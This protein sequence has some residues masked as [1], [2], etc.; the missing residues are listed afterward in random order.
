MSFKAPGDYPS[1]AGDVSQRQPQDEDEDGDDLSITSTNAGDNDSEK[2]WDVDDVLAERPDPN[3]PGTRQYLIMWEGFKLE[4]CTW[5]PIENLGDGLFAKW[6]ENKSE[7]DAGVRETFDLATYDAACAER[8]ERHMR[9]NAKRQRLGLPLTIPFPPE[10]ADDASMASPADRSLFY[11][12]D[13]AQEVDEV[14]DASTPSSKSRAAASTPTSPLETATAM[15]KP[16]STVKRTAKQTTFVGVLPQAPKKDLGVPRMP[17]KGSDKQPRPSLPKTSLKPSMNSSVKPP[18]SISSSAAGSGLVR[19][20]GGG[21]MT[22][23]QGTARRSSI[24]KHATAKVATQ[25]ASTNT[26][27]PSFTAKGPPASSSTQPNVLTTK[28]LTATR[29]RKYPVSSDTNVFAGGKER[30]KRANLADVMADPSKAPKTFSNMRL[31]NIARKRAIEKGDMVGALSSIPRNFLLGNESENTR[32]RKSSLASPTTIEPPQSSEVPKPPSA[33]SGAVSK[34]HVSEDATQ[35]GNAEEAPTLKRKKTVHFIGEDNEGPIA[36]T[37]DIFHDARDIH[38]SSEGRDMNKGAPAPS[39]TSPVVAHQPQ[40]QTQTILKTVRFGHSEG[41]SVGFS[42]ITRHPAPW[43]STF[44]SQE[45]LHL[46]STCSSYHFLSQRGHIIAGKLSAGAVEP[47][48]PE[49]ATALKN[50]TQSLQ[51]G[52]IG[53]HLVAR[54]YSILVYPGE[55]NGWAWL[56]IDDKKINPDGLL[57]YL[58]FQSPFPPP[59]YPS[60]FHKEPKAFSQLIYPNGAGDP[61]IVGALTGLDFKNM[62]PQN[63]KWTDKQTYMLLIPL[64]ARQLLGIVMAWLRK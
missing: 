57:R 62:L 34:P 48:L 40:E 49:H 30:K 19:K 9:R 54:G 29:T 21:T 16:A 28:R 10:Y 37:C 61:E 64:K 56:D 26:T 45:I 31:R 4:D 60:K 25:S 46:A 3:V 53:L 63:L 11:S 32:P 47:A 59:A 51:R 38:T 35:K 17:E 39:V 1:R 33:P 18:A 14:D 55:C 12:D 15:P 44:K 22:G 42:G 36:T 20:E 6:E 41:I 8:T 24:F 13:E 43:L 27:T 5:E 7:I 23:Y 58:I 2:E 50:V 52:S